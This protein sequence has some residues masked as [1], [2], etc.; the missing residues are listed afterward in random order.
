M[1]LVESLE[2]S[3][4]QTHE[5]ERISLLLLPSGSEGLAGQ[6]TNPWKWASAAL[7]GR[8]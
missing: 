3:F 1:P 2:A 5:D 6:T 8:L 7:R 4:S